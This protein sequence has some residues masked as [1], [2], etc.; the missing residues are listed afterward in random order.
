MMGRLC[1]VLVSLIFLSAACADGPDGESTTSESAGQPSPTQPSPTQPPSDVDSSPDLELMLLPPWEFS[2]RYASFEDLGILRTASGVQQQYFSEALMQRREGVWYFLTRVESYESVAT[3]QGSLGLGR[4]APGGALTEVT[5]PGG[6]VTDQGDIEEFGTANLGEGSFGAQFTTLGIPQVDALVSFTVGN[7]KATVLVVRLDGEDA[8]GDANRLAQA[9]RDRIV[10]VLAGQ[11]VSQSPPLGE[12]TSNVSVLVESLDCTRTVAINLLSIV[13][14]VKNTGSEPALGLQVTAILSVDRAGEEIF[15]SLGAADRS[16][17][18]GPLQPN[19]SA[20]FS[21]GPFGDPSNR[22]RY[23]SI[24]V[25]D[26]TRTC[27]ELPINGPT[28]KEVGP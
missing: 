22:V 13:G 16:T 18:L 21:L 2:D 10:A 9:L 3:A 20:N 7:I 24:R 25:E 27:V 15:I 6:T 1:I 11:S 28:S 4:S 12:P 26:C 5:D 14:T 23:C 19:A 8:S 17:S